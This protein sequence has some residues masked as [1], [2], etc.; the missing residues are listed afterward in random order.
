MAHLQPR[1]LHDLKKSESSVNHLDEKIFEKCSS[2]F[3]FFLK[4]ARPTWVS[5]LLI[6]IPNQKKRTRIKKYLVGKNAND[7]IVTLHV[8]G[9]IIRLPFVF[10]FDVMIIIT[11][12]D[13]TIFITL[14]W[15]SVEI[16]ANCLALTDAMKTRIAPFFLLIASFSQPMRKLYWNTTNQISRLLYKV[17]NQI[18]GKW[19]TTFATFYELA[20][21]WINKIFVQTL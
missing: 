4:A 2:H 9:A 17:T 12:I 18:S 19:K 16:H 6:T 21:K 14:I 8:T 5:F 10:Y 15:K 1:S 7:W 11:K 20:Q 13:I 3:I